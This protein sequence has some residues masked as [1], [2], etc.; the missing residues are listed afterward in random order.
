MMRLLII[1]GVLLTSIVC[2]SQEHLI[3]RTDLKFNLPNKHW[4][5]DSEQTNNKIHAVFYKRKS[6]IN[7]KGIEVIPSIAIITEEINDSV[8]VIN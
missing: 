1:F 6:I 4:H 2:Y 8:E 7:K 5:F 3:D